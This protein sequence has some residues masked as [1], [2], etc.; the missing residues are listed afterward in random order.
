MKVCIYAR[1]SKDEHHDDRRFQDPMTQIEE[2]RKWCQA[3]EHDVVAEYIDKWSGAD[4]NR[5]AFKKALSEYWT[6]GYKAIVVW[7]YDRFTRE[8]MF[9]AMSYINSLRSKKV[10]V[11]SI[12][13]EWFNTSVDNP[14]AELVMAIMSWASAEERR[15]IS[16]R[17]KAGIARRR[18]IGQW[19]G[20]RPRKVRE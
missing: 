9:V 18:A 11:I 13:E 4:P 3:H 6:K 15:K 8:P 14:M 20:G 5:P 1:V 17:T 7:K 19:H 2:C 12:T 16:E 10:G